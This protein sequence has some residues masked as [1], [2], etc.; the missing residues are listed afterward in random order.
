MDYSQDAETLEIDDKTKGQ[1]ALAD[2]VMERCIRIVSNVN[3]LQAAA[4]RSHQ[5]LP[6]PLR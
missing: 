3:G 5:A 1:N 4:A 6:R 2:E